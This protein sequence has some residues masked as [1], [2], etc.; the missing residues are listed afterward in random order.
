ME[1]IDGNKWKAGIDI[2]ELNEAKKKIS[3]LEQ[4]LRIAESRE[5]YWRDRKEEEE[6]YHHYW[7]HTYNLAVAHAANKGVNIFMTGEDKENNVG[8]ILVK[9]EKAE[10]LEAKIGELEKDFNAAV[11]NAKFWHDREKEV[12]EQLDDLKSR[13]LDNVEIRLSYGDIVWTYCNG[14]VHV[15]SSISGIITADE[16][17]TGTIPKCKTCKNHRYFANTGG[18]YCHLPD[19]KSTI[20]G[21]FRINSLTDEEAE[22]PACDKF[23]ARKEAD[24]KDCKY[25]IDGSWRSCK[26][27]EAMA[28]CRSL[29]TKYGF[30]K[31]NCNG[32]KACPE[33]EAKE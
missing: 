10:E 24:C 29:K 17:A 32:K 18:H 22:G 31:N 12:K 25:H 21:I 20:P 28:E 5:T 13:T 26:D 16:I 15:S 30:C 2:P 9:N 7:L 11:E 14:F 23:E 4:K 6:D 3:E 8:V 1:S 19:S 33:F 27:G